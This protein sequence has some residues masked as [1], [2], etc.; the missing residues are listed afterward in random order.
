MGLGCNFGRELVGE[1]AFDRQFAGGQGV[2]PEAAVCGRMLGQ[3]EWREQRPEGEGANVAT[4][5]RRGH[6]LGR[7][8]D[9][10]RSQ[11]GVHERFEQGQS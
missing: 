5:S 6:R 7:V 2:S 9:V 10:V 8:A 4:R 11:T 3:R 1:V